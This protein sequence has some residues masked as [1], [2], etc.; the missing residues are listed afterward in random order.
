MDDKLNTDLFFSPVQ[1]LLGSWM[2]LLLGLFAVRL[3]IQL[4][5]MVNPMAYFPEFDDWHSAMM[6]Y[7]VLF[8]SQILILMGGWFYVW[9]LFN[10]R[11]IRKPK[12]GIILYTLGWVY[13]S[14]MLMRLVLGFTLLQDIHW[15]NQTLPA[16][17][18]LLLANILMLIGNYHRTNSIRL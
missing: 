13:W 16:L 3:I 18:H 15:F 2:I 8:A 14:I 12:L 9:R 10:T 5:V 1:R 11:V 17:F 4:Q 6:P 7:S